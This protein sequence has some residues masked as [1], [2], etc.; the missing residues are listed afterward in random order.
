MNVLSSTLLAELLAF[1]AFFA[2]PAYQFLLLRW[3]CR[4]E[5][6]PEIWYLPSYGF[7]IVIRNLP[8]KKVLFDIAHQCMLR[9]FVPPDAGASVG[10]FDDTV[11]TGATHFF[12][13]PGNDQ[14]LLSFRFEVIDERLSFAHTDKLGRRLRALELVGGESLVVD[15]TATIRNTLNFNM[16]IAKRAEV[17][18]MGLMQSWRDSS[19]KVEQRFEFDLIR[20]V[21]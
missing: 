9:R 16:R 18:L 5:G 3:I 20:A 19:Y 7:R 8:R 15:Y 10:T 2:F 14:V 1:I 17:D 13:F 21:Q 4:K 11:V 12:L 6:D